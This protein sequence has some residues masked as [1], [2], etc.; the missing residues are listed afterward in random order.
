MNFKFRIWHI[1][2]K[3]FVEK[4]QYFSGFDLSCDTVTKTYFDDGFLYISLD[5]ELVFE[6]YED[7]YVGYIQE[8]RRYESESILSDY[9]IQRF[10]GMKDSCGVEV[11]EGDIVQRDN[12]TAEVFW[13]DTIGGFDLADE[14]GFQFNARNLLTMKVVGHKNV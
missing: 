12:H 4:R 5:G 11:Y 7:G 14:F 10:T 2:S 1:P 8:R 6:D 9:V 13:N 3:K